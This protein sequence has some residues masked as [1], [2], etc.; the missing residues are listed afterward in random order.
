[1]STYAIGDVQGC[2]HSLEQLLTKLNFNPNQDK[3]WFCGDIVNRG[4]QSLETLRFI[5]N[6]NAGAILVLGNHD[7]TLL[8]LSV[9]AIKAREADTFESILT[10]PD[11]IE[12]LE[13]L[14]HQ[15]LLHHDPSLKYVLVHAGIYPYWSLEKAKQ[16]AKE[17]EIYLQSQNATQF[18][19]NM[20]G[21]E[22]DLWN[23]S[24]DGFERVR[25][26]TNA[27]TRMRFCTKDGRLNLSANGPVSNSPAD[28][29]PW[30]AFQDRVTLPDPI[31]F[32][33]WAAL[34]GITEVPDVIALDTGCAWGNCLTAICLET[35]ILTQV[36]CPKNRSLSV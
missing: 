36:S 11:K 7:L 31:I 26:I 14:Q 9:G 2:F 5:K 15:P 32:G 35:K 16:L 12:L 20:Y 28:C 10:A 22:P 33:H 30:F 17:V 25:F 1:M 19:F 23:D 8:A 21:N 6:L 27:F 4:P 34:G 13:W 18:L 24:L 29:V 3:L